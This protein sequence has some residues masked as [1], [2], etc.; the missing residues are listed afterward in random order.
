M[1]RLLLTVAWLLGI[2][3]A[4]NLPRVLSNEQAVINLIRSSE[5]RVMLLTPKLYGKSIANALKNLVLERGI[6]VLILTE[7]SATTDRASLIPTLSLLK[8]NGHPLE[9]RL[10]RRVSRN[11]LILDD[12]RLVIGPLIT[13]S[14]APGSS[15]TRLDLDGDTARLEASN[16]LIQWKRAKPWMLEIRNPQFKG[17]SR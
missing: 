6:P 5:R 10:L 1:R 8:R 13:G 15:E 9:V 4:Q 7:P 16:F 2:S 14:L 12:S 11:R 3:L 17:G